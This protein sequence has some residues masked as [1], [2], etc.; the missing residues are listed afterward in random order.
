M[1][2]IPG[3]VIGKSVVV[4]PII[5]PSQLSVA[6]GAL[7]VVI[8]HSSVASTKFALSATGAVTSSIITFCVCMLLLPAHC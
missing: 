2:V 3:V 5:V 8:L 1:I 4:V 6:L 7:R